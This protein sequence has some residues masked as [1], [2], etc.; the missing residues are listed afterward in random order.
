MSYRDERSYPDEP[1]YPDQRSYSGE[2]TYPDQRAYPDQRYPDQRSYPDER[3]YP[4]ER[5]GYWQPPPRR[6]FPIGKLFLTIVILAGIGLVVY[7]ILDR[8]GTNGTAAPT[9]AVE[10][11]SPSPSAIGDPRAQ[12]I[13]IDALLDESVAGR[14]RLSSAINDINACDVTSATR[15]DIQAAIDSRANSI[16]RLDA[17]EVGAIPEGAALKADLR[18]ALSASHAADVAYLAWVQAAGT[19]CPRTTDATFAAVTAANAQATQAKTAF[20]AKWNPV[21]TRYGLP[22]TNRSANEI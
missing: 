12:A 14:A 21:A 16:T 10:S 17:L 7:Y 8:T 2:P 5:G 19:N 9:N 15:A 4:E 11:H 18:A 1:T 13:A 22:K 20:V 6:S 3:S